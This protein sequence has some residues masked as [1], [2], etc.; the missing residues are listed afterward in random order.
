MKGLT[1]A[2]PRGADP[3]G[4]RIP[5]KEFRQRPGILEA[6]DQ[7]PAE[8]RRRWVPGSDLGQDTSGRPV[9]RRFPDRRALT[10]GSAPDVSAIESPSCH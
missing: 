2:R 5:S 8:P 6:I 1:T 4:D 9:D 10:D 7:Q 3:L